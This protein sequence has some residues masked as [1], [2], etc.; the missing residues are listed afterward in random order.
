MRRWKK[1][2][3]LILAGAFL[4]TGLAG[5]AAVSA[6][7]L[8]QVMENGNNSY[9]DTASDSSEEV[10]SVSVSGDTE[11]TENASSSEENDSDSAD[12]QD[13]DSSD[14]AQSQLFYADPLPDNQ[15]T[16]KTPLRAALLQT[17]LQATEQDEVISSFSTEPFYGGAWKDINGDGV[18]DYVWTAKSQ[19][20]GHRFNF[21][22]SF[23][24][25]TVFDENGTA[26]VYPADSIHIRVPKTILKDRRGGQGDSYEMSV[27]SKKDVDEALAGG[28]KLDED[29]SFGYYED[30]D[31]IVIYNF[32]DVD[33]GTDAFVELSYITNQTTF[34][35]LDEQESDPFHATISVTDPADQTTHQVTGENQTVWI[36]TQVELLSSEA[37]IPV[38]YSTWPW[39]AAPTEDGNGNSYDTED[40]TY[41]V[42]E[43]RSQIDDNSQMYEFSVDDTFS[44][45]EA[46]N[47]GQEVQVNQ[48]PAHPDIFPVAVRFSGN[49]SYTLMQAGHAVQNNQTQ[50]GLRY[51]YVLLALK[52]SFWDN[53]DHWEISNDTK[54]TVTPADRRQDENG[55]W[56][57]DDPSSE[58]FTRKFSWNKPSFSG[59]GG[60][61]G[62]WEHA[63]GM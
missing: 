20:A 48:D 54:V 16:D 44:G 57:G 26:L 22:I 24:L 49:G 42:W 28:E 46:R 36:D 12:Q 59:V 15:I 6:D 2:L 32:R 7:D 52:K 55:N 8:T 9:A 38:K 60:G 27:P 37:R 35:Y 34:N 30:G 53:M 61:F 63:D 43:I 62:S 39:G 4:F 47:G 3:S 18:E 29:M 41:L 11:Q 23:G 31:D 56:S 50:S 21:R 10:S 19:A 13:T 40:Y 58:T 1:I 25:G 17:P 45:L 51:D 33:A 5:N 14:A